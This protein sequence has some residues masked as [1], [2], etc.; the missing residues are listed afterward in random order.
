MC[1]LRDVRPWL[2]M[3]L[4]G[5]LL[6]QHVGSTPG[7]MITIQLINDSSLLLRVRI[8]VD[9]SLL[10]GWTLSL[11]IGCNVAT[12]NGQLLKSVPRRS[13]QLKS[14]VQYYIRFVCLLFGK[15]NIYG[16]ACYFRSYWTMWGLD[17]SSPKPSVG[18][19]VT[20]SLFPFVTV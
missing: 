13:Y 14:E 11:T 19:S 20:G 16:L 7:I 15:K 17:S 18:D 4:N 6:A 9:L 5:R 12:D 1:W 2:G 8:L 3:Q 10:E